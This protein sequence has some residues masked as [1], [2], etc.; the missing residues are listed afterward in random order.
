MED[1]KHMTNSPQKVEEESVQPS[2]KLRINEQCEF[3]ASKPVENEGGAEG[4]EV[5]DEEDEGEEEVVCSLCM[6]P[7][8]EDCKLLKE[9]QCP[10]CSKDAWK[11]CQT[12]NESLLSRTCPV[13]RGD[14]APIVMYNVPGKY[15]LNQRFSFHFFF[16]HS[17]ISLSLSRIALVFPRR[18]ITQ[19]RRTNQF[20]LQIWHYS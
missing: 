18:P 1:Q 5:Q 19:R 4:V 14:Y 20:T 2:K 8:T 10:Q 11:I 15:S 16:F 3:I 6:E 13:C 7:G 9:H 17:F 12:C